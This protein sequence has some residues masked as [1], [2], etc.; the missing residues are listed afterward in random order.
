MSLFHIMLSRDMQSK[1]KRTFGI[2]DTNISGPG[3]QRQ[4][5]LTKGYIEK[6]HK[7]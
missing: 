4:C 1:S 3:R 5:T 2:K 7:L 6:R